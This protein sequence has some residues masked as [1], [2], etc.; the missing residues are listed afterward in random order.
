[1]NNPRT[2]WSKLAQPST[3][4]GLRRISIHLP[5]LDAIQHLPLLRRLPGPWVS[6]FVSRS[7]TS[8]TDMRVY[9]SRY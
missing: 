9:L 3:A 5:P 1:M 7:Q 4:F 8:G 6:L 2:N